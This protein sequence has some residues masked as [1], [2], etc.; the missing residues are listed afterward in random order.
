MKA[1]K[2]TRKIRK[3]LIHHFTLKNWR[4]HQQLLWPRSN[5]KISLM[6]HKHT[7]ASQRLPSHRQWADW[8]LQVENM[9]NYLAISEAKIWLLSL[10]RLFQTVA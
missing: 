5:V 9:W 7:N 2:N 3:K 4:Q 1:S 10:Q 8:S 6:K